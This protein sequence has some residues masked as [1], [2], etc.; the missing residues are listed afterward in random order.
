MENFRFHV[1]NKFRN[2]LSK[3]RRAR[4]FAKT[5]QVLAIFLCQLHVPI[6]ARKYLIRNHRFTERDRDASDVTYIQLVFYI[7]FVRLI[8]LFHDVLLGAACTL[9]MI[10]A[11]SIKWLQQ[12]NL[13]QHVVRPDVMPRK[14]L[15]VFHSLRWTIE[16][17]LFKAAAIAK[18][19]W[20]S[21]E[22]IY[23]FV[24]DFY[25]EFF[26]LLSTMWHV[27]HYSLLFTDGWWWFCGL[28]CGSKT[29]CFDS[30]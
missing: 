30:R 15:T 22:K 3:T 20:S 17:R 2:I 4:K 12:H 7:F 11:R 16:S 19:M 23:K 25:C 9:V 24:T 10:Q 5:V 1:I 26:P 8:Q 28:F 29:Q 21:T 27:F 14:M 6:G 18:K 13:I